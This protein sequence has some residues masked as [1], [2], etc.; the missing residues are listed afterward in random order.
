MH[1]W[2]NYK[3]KNDE[4]INER[5]RERLA[6]QEKKAVSLIE[7]PNYINQFQLLSFIQFAD[8]KVKERS[9]LVTFVFIL[10]EY[11]DF[12]TILINV[13]NYNINKT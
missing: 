7:L 12:L 11:Q 1:Y 6:G 9:P 10:R 13:T 5:E 4:G 3:K 2:E 8:T